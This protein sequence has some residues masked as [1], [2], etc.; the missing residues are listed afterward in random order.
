MPKRKRGREFKR[1]LAKAIAKAEAEVGVVETLTSADPLDDVFWNDHE[2]RGA[3]DPDDDCYRGCD[4]TLA[5]DVREEI[6]VHLATR[7]A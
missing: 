7:Y 4:H 3:H 6:Q 1:R 2:G 5:H